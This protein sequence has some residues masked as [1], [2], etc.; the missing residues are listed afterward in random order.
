MKLLV[1]ACS[2][3]ALLGLGTQGIRAH[4]DAGMGPPATALT[5][6]YIHVPQSPEQLQQLVALIVD[7]GQQRPR[8]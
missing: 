7:A 2:L 4:L 8:A 3:A 6:P 5:I 1:R